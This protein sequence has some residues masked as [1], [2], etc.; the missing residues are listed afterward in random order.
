LLLLAKFK[1]TVLHARNL[2][3]NENNI[4][5]YSGLQQTEDYHEFPGLANFQLAFVF[6]VSKTGEI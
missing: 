5:V 6:V 2:L 4:Q 1:Q 3:I